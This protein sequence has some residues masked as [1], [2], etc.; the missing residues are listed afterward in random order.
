MAE[1]KEVDKPWG[2]VFQKEVTCTVCGEQINPFRNDFT[3][4]LTDA[5]G[6][7]IGVLSDL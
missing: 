6:L 1:F 3:N 5:R 2:W 4:E 7:N